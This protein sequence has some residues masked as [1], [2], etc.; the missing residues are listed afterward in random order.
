MDIFI[1]SGE[2]TAFE[3]VSFL[4]GWVLTLLDVHSL[5]SLLHDLLKLNTWAN[6]FTCRTQ[7]GSG[8]QDTKALACHRMFL[9]L[10][11]KAIH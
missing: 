3:C 4:A 9:T 1:P 10:R 5:P 8:H 11:E 7:N 2:K 6:L